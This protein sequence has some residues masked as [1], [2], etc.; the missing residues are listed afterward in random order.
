MHSRHVDGRMTEWMQDLTNE[1][2]ECCISYDY[3]IINLSRKLFCELPYR[4]SSA[5]TAAEY[6]FP[7]ATYYF[8]H[9]K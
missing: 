9:S 7:G 2:R 1:A 8:D 4:G 5:I 6:R 3:G